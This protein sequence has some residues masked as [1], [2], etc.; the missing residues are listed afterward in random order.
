MKLNIVD[1]LQVTMKGWGLSPPRDDKP[2]QTTPEALYDLVRQAQTYDELN[3]LTD[4]YKDSTGIGFALAI[5]SQ[6]VNITFKGLERR[7]SALEEK[8]KV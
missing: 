8:D 3:Q 6:A 4:K 5:Q 2:F 1:I 7:V